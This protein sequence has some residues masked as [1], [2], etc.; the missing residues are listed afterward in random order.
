MRISDWSSD[1]CSSDL[2]GRPLHRRRHE[3]DEQGR[4]DRFRG[5]RAGEAQRDRKSVVSGKSVSER[6]ALGGS[7]I[8]KTK[9]TYP[10]HRQT[11]NH[12]TISF[13]SHTQ[14]Q[15]LTLTTNTLYRTTNEHSK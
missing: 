14:Y 6:V 4:D 5:E 13:N 3:P 1:V 11:V 9:I 7:R 12:T 15:K 8:I 10:T 2:T